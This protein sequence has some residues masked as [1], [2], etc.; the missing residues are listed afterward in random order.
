MIKPTL[1]CFTDDGFLV[2]N[3]CKTC[4]R[5]SLRG[6]LDFDRVWRML[7]L[8]RDAYMCQICNKTDDLNIHH[9][10]PVSISPHR[11]YDIK[12]SRTLCVECHAKQHG[13]NNTNI[14]Y[15]SMNIDKAKAKAISF[16]ETIPGTKQYDLALMR[17]KNNRTHTGILIKSIEEKEIEEEETDP[18]LL[19]IFNKIEKAALRG[20]CHSN[21][22]YHAARGDTPARLDDKRLHGRGSPGRGRRCDPELGRAT[23]GCPSWRGSPRRRP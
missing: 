17:R 6:E 12:N 11:K 7:V 15:A 2:K 23:P 19:E 8:D 20:G 5:L 10:V 14:R 4:K 3:A 18:L 13:K 1:C 22:L 16:L 9:I 21:P